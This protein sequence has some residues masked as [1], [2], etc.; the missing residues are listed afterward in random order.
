M[1]KV[2]KA[3]RGSGEPAEGT[4]FEMQKKKKKPTTNQTNKQKMT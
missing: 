1:G 3:G 2:S 4:A